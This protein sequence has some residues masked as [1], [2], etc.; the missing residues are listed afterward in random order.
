M[1]KGMFFKM[2]LQA[3]MLFCVCNVASAC[4]KKKE[5]KPAKQEVKIQ[6]VGGDQT[7]IFAIPL[8]TSEEEEDLQMKKLKSIEKKNE[9]KKED[10]K[11]STGTQK[12]GAA[13]K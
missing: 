1:K 12:K 13:T 9:L 10:A 3:L 7:D 5:E 2:A 8:D 11:G 4:A 6:D